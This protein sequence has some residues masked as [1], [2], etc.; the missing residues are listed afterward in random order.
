[1]GVTQPADRGGQDCGQRHRCLCT[2][3]VGQDRA[4]RRDQPTGVVLTSRGEPGWLSGAVEYEGKRWAN[5]DEV[6]IVP[7]RRGDARVRERH[8]TIVCDARVGMD[9]R[10]WKFSDAIAGLPA[11]FGECPLGTGRYLRW[12]VAPG[13]TGGIRRLAQPSLSR[14]RFTEWVSFRG[15]TA[16]RRSV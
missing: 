5:H 8:H 6:F 7:T 14:G 15:H 9:G 11:E 3:Q 10:R 16:G 4:E 12:P 13:R 2:Q 1:M